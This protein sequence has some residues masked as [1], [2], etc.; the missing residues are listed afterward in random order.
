MVKTNIVRTKG[1]LVK[2]STKD[3]KPLLKINTD[4][5]KNMKIC[6]CICAKKIFLE[7]S[8]CSILKYNHGKNTW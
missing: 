8:I 6:I 1:I 3:T 5:L 7:F 4:N 2:S